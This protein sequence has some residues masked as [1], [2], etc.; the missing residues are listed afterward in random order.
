MGEEEDRYL[1]FMAARAK[2]PPLTSGDTLHWDGRGAVSQGV[3]LTQG[4]EPVVC[5][6]YRSTGRWQLGLLPAPPAPA[7][8]WARAAT[9]LTFYLDPGLLLAPVHDV[10]PSVIGTLLWVHGQGD[11]RAIALKM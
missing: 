11:G 3:E 7:I 4:S 1:Q 5:S 2:P 6:V 8:D 10:I 9:A